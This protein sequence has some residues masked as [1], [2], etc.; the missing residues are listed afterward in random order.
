MVRVNNLNKIKN[1]WKYLRKIKRK[2]ITRELCD[3][4][5]S[6]SIEAIKYIPKRFK[7][8]EMTSKAFRDD[9]SLFNFVLKED[10]T[11]L[12]F[13]Y[14]F[15]RIDS[16]KD[17]GKRESNRFF[18]LVRYV[19]DKKYDDSYIYFL[20]DS[21]IPD[22]VI[23]KKEYIK[24]R[25]LF[26]VEKELS[27]YKI[28]E[29]LE[30]GFNYLNIS[31]ELSF[32]DFDS[33]YS[34]LDGNLENADI[35]EYDFKDINLKEYNL[36]NVNIMSSVL[37]SQGLYNDSFYN[38][39]IACLQQLNTIIPIEN[40]EVKSISLYESDFNIH[41]S[42]F[43]SK[44]CNVYYISDIHLDFKIKNRFKKYATEL[45]IRKYISEII[46]KMIENCFYGSFENHYLIIAGD[47]SSSFYIS[48]IFYEELILQTENKILP[49]NI[50]CIL[51]NHELWNVDGY[52]ENKVESIVKCYADLFKKLNI[53]FIQNEL[54]IFN[55]TKKVISSEQLKFMS[56][57]DIRKECLESCLTIFGGIGFAGY[58]ITFN[59][60]KLI[61]C[62][63]LIDI[64]KEKQY[65]KEFFSL[66][67]KLKAAIPTKRM[68]ILSHMPKSDW[69]DD[70][71]NSNWIYISGH[72]HINEYEKNNDRTIFSDNQIGYYNEDIALKK[73]DFSIKCN[74]FEFYKDGIYEIDIDLYIRF[75]YK[76][77]YRIQCSLRDGKFLLL[78]KN[79]IYMF[80]Y[81]KNSGKIYILNGGKYKNLTHD[82]VEYYYDNL[83]KYSDLL[84][85]GVNFFYE[86]LNNVSKYVKSFGGSGKIHGAIV[87][88]DYYNHIYVNFYDEQ[89]TPYW[90]ASIDYKYV[91]PSIN[92][93]IEAN[94]PDLLDKYN[95]VNSQ[96]NN[97][98]FVRKNELIDSC[99]MLDEDTRIYRESRIL[100]SI[101]YL[102]DDGII[103]I[104]NDAIISYG[105]DMNVL[106]LAQTL[107]LNV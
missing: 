50:I 42:D 52:T 107:K 86:Y 79:K 75:Y 89:I 87:D 90:A 57:D 37:L 2:N 56:N 101:Q 92:D 48:S 39:N 14:V 85:K 54:L 64:E 62:F 78:K 73:I 53:T 96:R 34:Y 16:I 40:E 21:L 1:D 81:Q 77:G 23:I 45:E 7:T 11:Y 55:P 10:L 28:L 8:K 105:D 22:T 43:S 33:F 76:M 71:Y 47:T 9:W 31:L 35:Y 36:E 18:S 95:S 60:S 58:N 65:T 97:S 19:I 51:G 17:Y 6:Q 93:L 26:I 69:S 66:Y 25:N 32:K 102:I 72:T 70:D 68:I 106:E 44:T 100:R 98:L 38:N 59:S 91:Y 49:R 41:F 20:I 29:Y 63:S 30:L 12:D 13:V 4:A 104:W 94:C 88:I 61:Y 67:L 15:K 83:D 5:F 84:K 27:R 46:R 3:I 103:R 74:I 82:N 80:I 99:G 24:E